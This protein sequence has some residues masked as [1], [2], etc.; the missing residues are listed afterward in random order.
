M[1]CCGGGKKKKYLVTKKD[2]TT[3]VVDSLSAAMKL[4]R[5]NGGRYQPIK[6]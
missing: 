2:G 4:I 3:E 1:G 6:V 5:A